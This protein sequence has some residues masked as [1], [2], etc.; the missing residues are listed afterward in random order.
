MQEKTHNFVIINKRTIDDSCHK[1]N[2]K[3]FVSS[4]SELEVRKSC[5]RATYLTSAKICKKLAYSTF[6]SYLCQNINLN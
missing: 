5:Y 3:P 6:I 2:G 1:T 4:F